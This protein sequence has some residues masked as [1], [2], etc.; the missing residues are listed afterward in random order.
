MV[1]FSLIIEVNIDMY[2]P[3]ERYWTQLDLYSEKINI[4]SHWGRVMLENVKSAIARQFDCGK[5]DDVATQL[6]DL[7]KSG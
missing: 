2:T 4:Q 5:T 7:V 6:Y 3:L 1:F